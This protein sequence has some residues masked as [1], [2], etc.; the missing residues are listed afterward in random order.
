[1]TFVVVGA[2]LAGGRAAESL[3]ERG[4]DGRLVLLG[5][6]PDRPYERPPL[7]KPAFA[8]GELPSTKVFLRDESWYEEQRIEL[9]LGARAVALDARARS[10]SLADGESLAYD[11]LLIATGT[12]VR[13][14]SAPGVELAG[15]HYLRTI[16]EAE[17]IYAE[18]AAATCVV[19]IGAGFIGAEVAATARALGK[20]VK[21]LEMLP[22]PLGRALGQQMGQVC[23]EIHRERGTDLR[24]GVQIE[25]LRG[26]GRVEEVVLG[27]GTV[28]PADVVVVGVGVSPAVGWLEGS[29]IALANGVIVDEQCRSSIPDVFAAGDVASWPNPLFG[30]RLRVEHYDNAQNQGLHAAGSM[31]GAAESYAPVPYFWSDQY[32]LTLQYV[33]HAG[34]GERVVTRGDVGSRSFTAW[35][36]DDAGVPSAAFIVGRPRDMLPA[37]RI[38]GARRPVDLGAL[39]DDSTDLRAFARTLA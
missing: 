31:L 15:V 37:R 11:K 27:D 35:Y 20:E 30:H 36:V 22:V 29:G 16:R 19:V 12:Q 38:V 18:I 14:L 3:R 21:L 5:A 25:A 1:M 33:G 8:R 26:A 13:H 7:S 28:L 9:R 24:T 2:S 32:E 34:G 4:Y 39:T 17:R 10:V 23:G 6:E